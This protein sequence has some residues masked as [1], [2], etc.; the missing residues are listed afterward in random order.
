M[1]YCGFVWPQIHLSLLKW[2][3][4]VL[5]QGGAS[6]IKQEILRS[7]EKWFFR[8]TYM[9]LLFSSLTMAQDRWENSK[10]KGSSSFLTWCQEWRHDPYFSMQGSCTLSLSKGMSEGFA[11]ILLIIYKEK[12][13][14]KM[15][16]ALCPWNL[17]IFKNRWFSLDRRIIGCPQVSL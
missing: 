17:L 13:V 2:T 4:Q 16:N 11:E 3:D 5:I 7:Q 10:E 15:T 9:K 1:T 14:L 6:K 8:W 12:C